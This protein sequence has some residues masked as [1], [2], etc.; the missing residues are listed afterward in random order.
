MRIRIALLLLCA[1]C[2]AY[3]VTV[4]ASPV[5]VVGVCCSSDGDCD[6]GTC[7]PP[8]PGTRNCNDE[9]I[10]YCR[11]APQFSPIGDF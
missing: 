9:K 4:S 3:S 5:D 10:G 11:A 6:G 1:S 7:V 2:V 8:D